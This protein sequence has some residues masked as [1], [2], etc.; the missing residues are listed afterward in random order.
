MN[1]QIH[2][3]RMRQRTLLITIFATVIHMQ[4]ALHYKLTKF[5]KNLPLVISKKA[6]QR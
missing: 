2:T 5:A 1:G 3:Y 6:A 4:L